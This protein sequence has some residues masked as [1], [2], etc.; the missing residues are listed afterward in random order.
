[1]NAEITA[2]EREL[3]DKVYAAP[4]D[5]GPRLVYADWLLEQ[6]SQRGE[7]IM[8]QY[9]SATHGLSPDERKREKE[10]IEVNV[11]EW[12]G[13][14]FDVLDYRDT[15]FARG[16]LSACTAWLPDNP[17]PALLERP[18]W[19]TVER[20]G[21]DLRA[22]LYLAARGVR[23]I[24]PLI[25]STLTKLLARGTV[26]PSV[27][28]LRIEGGPEGASID[29]AL[30]TTPIFP[31]LKRLV[32]VYPDHYPMRAELRD[33]L[34]ADRYAAFLQ[35]RVGSKL[36]A[37]AVRHHHFSLDRRGEL[38]PIGA[39]L[40]AW[41]RLF[42]GSSLSKM[43]FVPAH[44]LGFRFSRSA[45]RSSDPGEE[46]ELVVE[47]HSGYASAHPK[48]ISTALTYP[49][50]ARLR[51][52]RLDQR[53]VHL[54]HHTILMEQILAAHKN[55]R[56]GHRAQSGPRLTFDSAEMDTMP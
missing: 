41:A 23:S 37:F 39:A 31:Q 26:L 7:L 43:T 10:L 15:V 2:V 47:W 54:P 20:I 19:S 49:E 22:I 44:G 28:E 46:T 51:S 45:P 53:G 3:L 21:G 30:E 56:Y 4:F 16:F 32:F 8:L 55:A 50:I 12:L 36:E 29:R 25:A 24:G 34:N 5:D 6:G 33:T 11:R 35:S 27:E 40:N 38:P 1:M 17:D 48:I 9:K 13:P 14:L 42:R 18:E 52:V